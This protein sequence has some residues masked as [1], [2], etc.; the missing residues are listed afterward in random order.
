MQ[1]LV[2]PDG[3]RFKRRQALGLPLH[4]SPMY[5]CFLCGRRSTGEQLKSR[6]LLGATR[7]VCAPSCKPGGSS[8]AD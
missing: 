5:S 1:D 3:L 4:G 7:R 8:A 2:R 6:R